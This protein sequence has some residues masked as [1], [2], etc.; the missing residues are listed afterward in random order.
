MLPRFLV[1]KSR[2]IRVFGQSL[3]SRVFAAQHCF[4]RMMKLLVRTFHSLSSLCFMGGAR[5][6]RQELV[7]KKL[8]SMHGTLGSY[9]IHVVHGGCIYVMLVLSCYQIRG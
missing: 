1:V 8:F 7:Y 6:E 4:A 2:E 3:P 9:L 5:R